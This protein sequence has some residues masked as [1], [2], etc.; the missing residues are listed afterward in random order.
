MPGR[1]LHRRVCATAYW[2]NG[3][4]IPERYWIPLETG[5]DYTLTP[6][7]SPLARFRNDI[8]VVSGLDNPNARLAGVGND[9][10]RSMS[11]LVSGENKPTLLHYILRSSG[12]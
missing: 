7:L 9:H 3:N 2:F 4:G 10:Q 11:A 6:C 5:A 12:F 1:T 8:H